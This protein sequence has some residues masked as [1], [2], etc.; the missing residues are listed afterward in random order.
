[1]RRSLLPP[2]PL[3]PLALIHPS[4]S[5]SLQDTIDADVG[6]AGVIVD[7][8]PSHWAMLVP[9]NTASG[10]KTY[11]CIDMVVLLGRKNEC[12]LRLKHPAVS[13][14]HCILTNKGHG[15]IWIEDLSTNGTYIS[16]QILGKTPENTPIKKLLR[17]GEE[18]R[19]ASAPFLL[20][21]R[22]EWCRSAQCMSHIVHCSCPRS[23]LLT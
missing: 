5:S 4:P 15:E 18:V 14:K 13:G 19:S 23:H 12:N 21:T 8:A 3:A 16:G 1:L 20:H 17:D 9:L 10:E 22:T 2:S 6:P 11:R 7:V